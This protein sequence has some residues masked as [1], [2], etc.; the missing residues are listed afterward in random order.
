LPVRVR[1]RKPGDRILLSS[2][3][4]KIKDLL[5]D[6]KIGILTREKILVIEK[7][8]EI[9]AVPGI[10]RSRRLQKIKERNILIRVE[11]YEG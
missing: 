7:D 3:Y 5:I 9:I 8:G 6:K 4:K 1:S 2:G 10:A 11:R